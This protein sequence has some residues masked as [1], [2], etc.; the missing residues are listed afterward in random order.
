MEDV[1]PRDGAALAHGH[2]AEGSDY[3]IAMVYTVDFGEEGRSADRAF[4]CDGFF[5]EDLASEGD[6]RCVSGAEIGC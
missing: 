4:G 5:G 6:T 3:G 2:R 1:G